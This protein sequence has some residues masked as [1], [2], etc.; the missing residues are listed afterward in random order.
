MDA[1]Y[2]DFASLPIEIVKKHVHIPRGKRKGPR[3]GVITPF[4]VLLVEM[5]RLTEERIVS[6]LPHG[7]GFKVHERNAFIRLLPR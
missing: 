2:Q 3:G 7:R 4:P 1:S 6:W 5:L